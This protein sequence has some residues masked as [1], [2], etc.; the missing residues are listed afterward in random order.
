MLLQS[1]NF[2]YE[3]KNL[4]LRSQQKLFTMRHGLG[5][6]ASTQSLNRSSCRGKND[7]NGFDHEIKI[8]NNG[9][10]ERV[11]TLLHQD[12]GPIPTQQQEP[13]SGTR[14]S[15]VCSTL[16][17]SSHA[18]D[19]VLQQSIKKLKHYFDKTYSKDRRDEE[20]PRNKTLRDMVVQEYKQTSQTQVS[21]SQ[22][23]F[24]LLQQILELLDCI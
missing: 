19:H 22:T 12:S 6:N 18:E 8:V 23:P 17:G 10:L 20:T 4:R 24:A 1:H 5:S 16:L 9:S 15:R 3:T 11:P 2:R 21:F 7:D 13:P 14:G